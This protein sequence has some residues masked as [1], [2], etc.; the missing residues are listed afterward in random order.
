MRGATSATPVAAAVGPADRACSGS[1]RN[2][3]PVSP[4]ALCQLGKGQLGNA[5]LTPLSSAAQLRER[6]REAAVSRADA[7]VPSAAARRKG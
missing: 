2:W 6:R 5:L 1:R 4:R 7:M 3:R